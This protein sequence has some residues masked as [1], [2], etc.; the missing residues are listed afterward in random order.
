MQTVF[1][2]ILDGEDLEVFALQLLHGRIQRG[3]FARTGGARDQKNAVRHAQ[4]LAHGLQRWGREVQAFE[5]EQIKVLFQQTHDHGLTE[6][7]GNGGHA[8]VHFLAVHPQFGP[9]V[10]GHAALGDVELG[11]NLD[12]R[13]NGGRILV[14]DLVNRIKLAIHTDAHDRLLFIRLDV[15]VRCLCGHRLGQDLA[16]PLDDGRLRRHVSQVFNEFG[17]LKLVGDRVVLGLG[18]LHI[19][20]VEL[21]SNFGLQP[22]RNPGNFAEHQAQ[23]ISQ[24]RALW[25]HGDKFRHGLRIFGA[26]HGQQIVGQ[27]KTGVHLRSDRFF[28]RKRVLTHQRQTRLPRQSSVHID[29]RNQ[30]QADQQTPQPAAHGTLNFQGSLEVVARQFLL[31]KEHFSQPGRSDVNALHF[32]YFRRELHDLRL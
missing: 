1:D 26:S 20:S 30:P 25:I 4:Q 32:T 29:L 28:L 18:V 3:G 6:H 2:W 21:G 13:D 23:R 16:H 11:Q 7:G 8:R 17:C 31:G 19:P 22:K 5:R 10:L 12:A 14:V 27:Q 15:N 9:P 24:C